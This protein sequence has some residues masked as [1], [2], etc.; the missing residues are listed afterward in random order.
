MTKTKIINGDTLKEIFRRILDIYKKLQQN[1]S[2]SD[3]DKERLPLYLGVQKFTTKEDMKLKIE[4]F[5]KWAIQVLDN[6]K[7]K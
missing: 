7:I 2:L 6:L 1:E 4:E 3:K 5:F